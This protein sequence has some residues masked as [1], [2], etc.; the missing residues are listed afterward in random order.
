MKFKKQVLG[1]VVILAGVLLAGCANG[2]KNATGKDTNYKSELVKR[3]SLT[4]GL[5]GT[6]APYSYRDNGKL[7]GFEVELGQDIAK[8]IGVK[9]V[10]VPTKWDSLI[11]G[12]GSG[13]YDVILNNINK[14]PQRAKV[15]AFAD[16]YIYSRYVLISRSDEKG[17]KTLASIKGKK[18]VE[19]T[20]TDN[21]NVATKYGAT[22]VPNGDFPTALGLIRQD[23]VAATINSREAFLA[24]AKSNPTSDLKYVDL[25]KTLAPTAVQ[26][27]LNKQS[28]KLLAKVSAAIKELRQDGTLTKLSEKYFGSD[29]TKAN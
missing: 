29:I 23:R 14:T 18:L 17:L 19:G 16:P 21:F 5:E 26:P 13:R 22:V 28:P 10:F 8:K 24:Y 3:G 7:T 4:I 27:M 11:A 2:G 25:S 15:Y 9:P 1:T 12:L 6:F 20:G